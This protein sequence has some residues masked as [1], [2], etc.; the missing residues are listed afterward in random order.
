VIAADPKSP[1]ASQALKIELVVALVLCAAALVKTIAVSL[2]SP[3]APGR[4]YLIRTKGPVAVA[5]PSAIPLTSGWQYLPDPGN[6][7]LVDEWGEGGATTFA[8]AP[9]SIP[10]SFNPT[11]S[12]IDDRGS[13]AWYRI[14]FAGPP[15]HRG[16]AWEVSFEQVR[17]TANVW[18]NGR[19][20]GASTDAYA[21]FTLPASSLRPGATN[22]LIVRV[23]NRYVPGSPAQD[24]WNYG[25]IMRPVTLVPVGRVQLQNL[26]AMPELGCNYGCGR[27]LVVGTLTNHSPAALAPRVSVRV[28][29]PGGATV[30]STVQQQSALGPG[31]S[32]TIRFEVPIHG[33]LALWG[34][35]HPALYGVSVATRAQNRVEQFNRL[36]VGMRSVRVVRGVLYLN[37]RRLW[38]HG[39]SIVDDMPGHGAALTSTDID[40]VVSE[41]QSLGANITRAHYLLSNEMLDKLDRAGIL[42]WDQPPVYHYDSALQTASGR[43]GALSMLEKTIIAARSHP[44]VVINSVGNELSPSPSTTPGTLSYLRQAI[45]LA[46]RLDPTA[47]VGLDIYCYPG[48]PAQPIYTKLNVIGIND[49]YGWYPGLAGHSV[50]DFSQLAP[51]LTL[52]HQRYP[53]QALVVSEFGAEALYSGPTNVKG[54]YQFQVDYL[55]NTLGVLGTLPFMNGSIYWTLREFAVRP[56]WKGGLQPLAQD[57]PSGLTYKGMITYDGTAK[58]AFGVAQQLFA[59]PPPFVH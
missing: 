52:Q 10:S 21:P 43:A 15:A 56:G 25:G 48:F 59:D 9:V 19:Y 34:P 20:L 58:P 7:G 42:V 17:R 11:L 1:K 49:Y 26:G 27:L 35:G 38:L 44:S 53:G 41:L 6:I 37:G 23:D 30:A 13:V 18:L 40:T 55:R 45:R 2:R 8:W 32:E 33:P 22:Q 36:D 57:P 5:P 12:P 16:R 29:A 51:Y 31:A 50:A 24:W 54:T 14:D 28:T 46:R 4:G 39:A 47:P 3:P